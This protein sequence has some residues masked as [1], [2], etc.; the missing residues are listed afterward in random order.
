MLFPQPPLLAGLEFL[1]LSML[2]WLGAGLLPWLVHRFH[3]RYHHTTPWAAVELLLAAIEQHAWRIR[4]QQWLLL[5]LRT[6]ILLLVAFSAAKPVWRQWPLGLGNGGASGGDRVHRILVVDRSYSMSCRYEGTTR[7]ERALSHVHRLVE[8]ADAVTV[9]AWGAKAENVVGCPTFDTAVA[10]SAAESFGTSYVRAD[11]LAALQAAQA[12]L[13]RAEQEA[14]QLSEHQIF[15]LTDLG[16]NT[17]AA[18]E[19]EQT[20]LRELAEQARIMVIDVG[21]HERENVAVTRLSVQPR[22]V[23][24]G[25]EVVVSATLRNFGRQKRDGLRVEFMAEGRPA[26]SQSIDL[27]AG[28]A[29][30]VNFSHQFIDEAQYTVEVAVATET[31]CLP[32]DN[33]RWLVVDVRPQLRVACLEGRP[34]AAGDVARALSFAQGAISPE[35]LSANRLSTLDL[36]TYD[37]VLLADVARLSPRESAQLAQYVRTGGALAVLLG[38]RSASW[39]LLPVEISGAAT[40]G[41]YRFDPLE[42]RHRIVKPF[43]GREQAGLLSVVISRYVPMRA[44]EHAETVLAFD[45]GDPALVVAKHGLGSVA[46]LALP[47]SL[48]VSRREPWSSFAVNPSFLPVIR[49]L[50]AYLLGDR[51]LEQHNLQPGQTAMT[52]WQPRKRDQE[53]EVRQPSGS[54]RQLPLPGAEDER[55]LV[56]AETDEIGVYS[57]RSGAEEFA[58]FAVNLDAESAN[59][60]SELATIA[61]GALPPGITTTPVATETQL[62]AADFSFARSLLLGAVLLLFAEQTLAWLLGRGQA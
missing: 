36:T 46:V 41:A 48:A 5:A 62:A 60:D 19:A 49:E 7:H 47:A 30:G 12:A 42:Y 1:S 3:R 20:L 38:E 9:I 50:F 33:R 24:R 23:L 14:P 58:R 31:D 44:G 40:D 6:A 25:R 39:E 26:G 37:A 51:W 22:P 17:W 56:F 54:S 28:G 10:L 34:D 18:E 45:T 27:P 59:S 61:A 2:A 15:F 29:R 8:G 4:L 35:V 43:R 21:R 52:L 11:L 16:R 53:I 55:Q 13:V 57:L 32:V